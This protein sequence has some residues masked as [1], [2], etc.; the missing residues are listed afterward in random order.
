VQLPNCSL[1][2]AQA[3]PTSSS[4]ACF[5]RRL[6]HQQAHYQA[7][8]DQL[9]SALRNASDLD[10]IFRWAV[11]GIVQ[12][13]QVSRCFVML[14]KY[15]N[16]LHKAQPM[17]APMVKSVVAAMA[18]F[19]CDLPVSQGRSPIPLR[20]TE[21]AYGDYSEGTWLHHAFSVADCELCQ[22]VLENTNQPLIL[23]Q[24]AR[25][26]LEGEWESGSADNRYSY[27]AAALRPPNPL[28]LSPEKLEVYA[29]SGSVVPLLNLRDMPAL[30][31]VPLE[32][33]DRV[34]GYL[35]V[36]HHQP[37]PWQLEEYTFAR[38]V[39]THLSTAI[40]QAHTLQQVQSLV[41]ERTS[42]LQ[43]SL[44][45]QAKLYN[46][47]RQQIRQLQ[48]LNRLKDDFLSTM[49]HELRTPLTSMMLAIRMLREAELSPERR[50][51]YLDVLEQQCVQET[52]LI[53][54]L[55]ELQKLETGAI[56]LDVQA[57]EIGGWIQDFA[58][59]Q[60]A[61]L[62]EKGLNLEVIVPI[63]ALNLKTELDSLNRILL[64]LLSNARKYSAPNTT[65]QIWVEPAQMP[66]GHV[67][68]D[69]AAFIDGV[70]IAVRSVGAGIPAEDL[71]VI[72]NKFRRGQGV[73]DRAV[74]GTGLGLALVKG[75]VEHLE[76]M[77]TVTSEP[78]RPHEKPAD[79][80]ETCFTV[81][82]PR[83]P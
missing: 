61:L 54:D 51:K 39:A 5:S 14:L 65:V 19:A 22:A 35:A 82:I 62:V 29:A 57:V 37:C 21:P 70:A 67:S 49:S 56:S 47:T 2:S 73:T 32:H 76:G 17:P 24:L 45:V 4:I 59:G 38:L 33:Q 74:P 81:L 16:P 52:K 30:M 18:P 83:S 26:T 72:F 31:L 78:L 20:A 13:L 40:I 12:A 58:Q 66:R 55:L 15:Q 42:Q 9:T 11:E 23:P 48:E 10:Q 44:E 6:I 75:L 8:I 53:N 7:L 63:S 43:R 46:K 34:L 3:M 60:E 25:S 27:P 77:I 64:E 41:E 69:R 1:Q 79:A 28:S 80:W 36:Q 71:P 50:T 68:T